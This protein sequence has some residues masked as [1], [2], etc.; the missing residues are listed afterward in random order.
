MKPYSK[1]V[2]TFTLLIGT[3]VCH[4]QNFEGSW[5]GA[6]QGMPLIFDISNNEGVY[7]AKMQSPTQSKVFLPMDSTIVNGNKITLLLNAYKIKYSGNIEGEKVKGTFTQGTYSEA[8]IL[9]KKAY[10]EVKPNRP[11][12]PKAPFPYTSEEVVFKNPKANNIKLAGTLTL[13]N[14]VKN[15]PVAIMISGSGPQDRNEELFN[16]KPFLVI[17]DYLAKNGIAVLRYD[18]RGVAASQGDHKAA[19]S[20]DFATDVEAAIT[21]LKTRKD[22]NRKVIGL[23]GHSEGGLI[24]PIVIANNKKDVAFFVSL[25][26]PGLRGDEVLLPQMR[27]SA[28]FTGA[29][30]DEIDFEINLMDQLFKK[31]NSASKSNNEDLQKE[32]E[33][34]MAAA[35]TKAPTSLKSKYSKEYITAFTKEFS[36]NWMRYFLTYD[37]QN[38]LE[39]VT[40]PVLAINGSLDYQVM[41]DENLGGMK[42]AF[43]KAGNKDVTIK[44]L[45]GLNHLFQ[46]AVTGSAGEYGQIEETFDQAT[47]ELIASWI[48]ERFN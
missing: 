16:H 15:P 24:A 9:E 11:Q 37:P 31:I 5:T 42:S 18:D 6:I 44:K 3:L 10:V 43:A 27:K 4:S 23:I 26:G 39:K 41:A 1:L 13:P 46:N 32:L 45:P 2:A 35:V 48:N 17:A 22:I 14:G 7:T 38:N 29:P 21:Y 47:L 8:M 33:I 40:C 20:A 34:M 30:K 12:E 28:S 19:T 25:A 36:N